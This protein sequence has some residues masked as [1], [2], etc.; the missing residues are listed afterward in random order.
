FECPFC[1]RV[2]PTIKQLKAKYGP[3]KLRIVWKHHPLPFHKAARPAHEAAAA[4]MDLAGSEAFWKVHDLAFANHKALTPDNFKKWA[5][6][7][8]VDPAKF[9]AALKDKKYAA[10]VDEDMAV[11]RKIGASGTPAFRIN[12]VELSGAQPVDKFVE[13]IDAQ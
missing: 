3:E 2:N 12:G 11:A 8:G 9:E 10:K 6:E 7:A 4:V 1:G 13:I 5:K